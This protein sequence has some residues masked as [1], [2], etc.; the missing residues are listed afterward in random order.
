M[1]KDSKPEFSGL[2]ALSEDDVNIL[3]DLFQARLAS[4]PA[5]VSPWISDP[6]RT[7]GPV[8]NPPWAPTMTCPLCGSPVRVPFEPP[9][10]IY[11]PPPIGGW[12]SGPYSRPLGLDRI[13]AL[14]ARRAPAAS[15]AFT[16]RRKRIA[17]ELLEALVDWKPKYAGLTLASTLAG[18]SPTPNGGK[19]EVLSAVN[20]SDYFPPFGLYLHYQDIVADETLEEVVQTLARLLSHRGHIITEAV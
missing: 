12:P 19:L 2:S 17:S 3:F 8:V 1:T 14:G 4:D 10:P 11:E 16:I 6:G 13:A 5:P 15:R 7:P 9:G 20:H 18:M